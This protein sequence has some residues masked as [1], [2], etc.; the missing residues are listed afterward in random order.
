[1]AF[2]TAFKNAKE[3]QVGVAMDLSTVGAVATTFV[4]IETDSVSPPTFND[5]KL[6]RRGGAS[7]GI[8]S[9]STD[10]FVYG[11]GQSIEGSVSGL[12]T[13]TL[14]PVLMAAATGVT[15]A[16]EWDIDG[17]VDTNLTF[18]HG[19]TSASGL[20]VSFAYN[21]VGGTGFD[22]CV[23]IPG[24]VITSLTLTADP[25]EDGGRMK[26]DLS[27]VSRTP[28]TV[29]ATYA[30]ALPSSGAISAFTAEDYVFLSDYSTHTQVADADV[31]MKSFSF[32]IENPVVFG[33]FGGNATD[34]APMT[35][36][37]SVPEM[38]VTANPVVKYDTNVAA[39]WEAARGTGEGDQTASLTS[40][41]FEIANH[42]TLG[43]TRGISITDGV[44]TEMA[45][46]EGDYLGVSLTIKAKGDATSS[47]FIK[48]A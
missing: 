20:T 1:M 26:F 16:T 14:F 40:P 44:L 30:T 48:H 47:V 15:H 11:V 45:W 43:G 13:D 8:M 42:A 10:G 31:L 39:L 25:N 27:Y 36:I 35:Y 18:E 5:I 3:L 23:T 17:T 7:S 34:G 21:G 24:C 32:T 38:I 12:M 46:D 33:G 2:N 37:R 9:A 6:D 41:A 4:Q 19:D 28:L 29:G 22:D